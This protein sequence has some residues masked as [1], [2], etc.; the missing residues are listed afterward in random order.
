MPE[1]DQFKEHFSLAPR[2]CRVTVE[3]CGRQ[4]ELSATADPQYIQKLA[5][6]V[7]LR[8]SATAQAFPHHGVSR[9]A[10]LTL[11]EMADE[12]RKL[13][14]ALA[15]QEALI[16]QRLLQMQEQMERMLA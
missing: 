9:A 7:D 6:E 16:E 15:E 4:Y 13:E 8:M 14:A 12:L 1:K 2:R 3:I 11:L 10:I 5:E